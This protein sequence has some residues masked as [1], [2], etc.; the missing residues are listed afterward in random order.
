MTGMRSTSADELVEDWG[1]LLI[2]FLLMYCC[3][4]VEI[5]MICWHFSEWPADLLCLRKQNPLLLSFLSILSCKHHTT[6]I[7]TAA[8]IF[9]DAFWPK[10]VVTDYPGKCVIKAER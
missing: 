2:F 8:V 1:E 9:V 4:L 5:S 6:A 7:L 3:E 10:Y